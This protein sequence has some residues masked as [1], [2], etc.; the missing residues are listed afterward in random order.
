MKAELQELASE[1]SSLNER[2]GDLV[3]EA[4][5]TQARGENEAT[6]ARELERELSRVRRSLAKAEQILG[7]LA[8]D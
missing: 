6:G 3:F 2:V 4:L 5:K 1:V 8:R 7:E